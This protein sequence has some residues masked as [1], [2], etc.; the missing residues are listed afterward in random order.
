MWNRACWGAL[1]AFALAAAC[2]GKAVIDPEAQ[3]GAGGTGAAS[4][5]SSTSSS[6]TTTSS[7][8]GGVAGSGG[9]TTNFCDLLQEELE[10][11]IWSAQWCDPLINALQCTGDTVILDTCGCP[12]VA[13]DT[14]PH[15]AEEALIAYDGWVAEGCGPFL[16]STCPPPPSSPWYC[17]GDVMM[18]EP[19]N[20]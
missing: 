18:C 4:T 13:N 5:T 12:V 7:G 20:E 16:C 17:D 15:A 6:T 8:T 3:T 10:N 19:A 2:G 9:T 1:A 14:T 11:A